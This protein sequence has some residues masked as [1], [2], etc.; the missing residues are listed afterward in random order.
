MP[1]LVRWQ[2]DDGDELL[3]EV[4]HDGP[5]ISPVSRAGD[6]IESAGTSL[7]AALGSVRKAATVVLGQFRDMAVRPDEVQVEFGV[8]L[9][10]EAGAVIA[11]SSVEGHLTVKLTWRDDQ[12]ATPDV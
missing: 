12:A 5:E 2:L 3:V 11:K 4:D 8:R 10:A 9:T 7:S 1:E 6:V